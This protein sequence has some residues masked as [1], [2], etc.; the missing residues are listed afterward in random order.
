MRS[1]TRRLLRLLLLLCKGDLEPFLGH[2][3]WQDHTAEDGLGSCPVATWWHFVYLG[4][5]VGSS[6]D[7]LQV[8]VLRGRAG[9]MGHRVTSS[10]EQR[11]PV[12]P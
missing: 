12:L 8:G 5:E 3:G 7:V 11:L 10:R 6:Q 4:K 2:E 9:A 1:L